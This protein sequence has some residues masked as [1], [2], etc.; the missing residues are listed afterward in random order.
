MEPHAPSYLPR[1][2]DEQLFASLMKGEYVFL[3]DSR[4]KGKS[5]MIAR[6]IVQLKE[7]GVSTVKLDLQRIGANVTAEQWYAGLMVGMGQELGVVDELIAYW[8]SRKSMGPLARWLGAIADVVLARCPGK[9]V[10]FIDE[11]DFVRALDFST[12]EF[13]AG[14][15]DCFNRRSEMSG[16]ERLTFC[17]VG[18]ATPGQLIRNVDITPFNIGTKIELTDFTLDETAR[19]GQI[20]SLDGRNGA[21]LMK[22]VH[23]WVNGHPYL[24]QLLCSRIAENPAIA[25]SNVVD[26]LVKETFFAPE[27]RHTEPNLAAV[28]QRILD[29]DVP[30][31]SIE[32]R[33][34]QVLDLYGRLLRGKGV[35][36]AEENP[37]I[38]SLKLAGVGHQIQG[39]LR[40]R[41]RVYQSVFN[42]GWRQ[43]SLPNAEL[44]RQRGAARLAMLRTAAVA[45]IVV[46]AVS[47]A[48][49][50]ILRI[51][52]DRGKALAML[53]QRTQDLSKVSSDRKV[54]LT[55]LEKRNEELKR[56]SKEREDALSALGKSNESLS[57]T[58]DARKRVVDE[59]ER[60]SSA[61]KQRN[62]E[63]A[64][65]SKERELALVALGTRSKELE[66]K[67]YSGIMSSI[68]LA[69]QQ[70]RFNRV[71]ELVEQSKR[72]P[73]RGWEWGHASMI[74]NSQ[75]TEFQVPESSVFE[76]QPDESIHVVTPDSIYELTANGLRFKRKLAGPQLIPL[77]R[78]GNIRIARNPITRN[79]V[80]RDANSDKIIPAETGIGRGLHFDPES[81]ALLVALPFEGGR[82]GI[83]LRP[84]DGKK[85]TVV[86]ETPPSHA[87]IAN[88]LKDGDIMSLHFGG[89]V[90]RWDPSGRIKWQKQDPY[91]V[92]FSGPPGFSFSRDG[93]LM[94]F[95]DAQYRVLEIRRAS[96]LTFVA[97]TSGPP[98]RA[99]TCTFSPDGSKL[100]VG[101]YDGAVRVYD[102][103]S[104]ALLR[105]FAG[106]AAKIR[107]AFLIGNGD[108]RFASVDDNNRLRVWSF[109]SPMPIQTYQEHKDQV[110]EALLIDRGN[111]LLSLSHYGLSDQTVVARDLR[112]GIVSKR[113]KDFVG[114]F[115]SES[116]VFVFLA[117]GKLEKLTPKNLKVESS[118]QVF[119]D[120]YGVWCCTTDQSLVVLGSGLERGEAASRDYAILDTR[121]M[122]VR[123]RL[124]L[125]WPR[126]G[127][128]PRFTLDRA[129]KTMLAT[130]SFRANR[131]AKLHGLAY[132]ISFPEGRVLK[133][134]ELDFPFDTSH[135]SPN[136][137]QLVIGAVESGGWTRPQILDIG[138]LKVV[139]SLP[140]VRSTLRGF[141]LDP[142][143]KILAGLVSDGPAYLWD[144]ETKKLIATLSPGTGIEGISFS[145][146]GSRVVTSGPNRTNIVWNSRTGEEVFALRY[147]PTRVNDQLGGLPADTPVF[148]SDGR[149]IVMGC[150]DGAVRIFDSL[151]WKDQP[152]AARK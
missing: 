118:I 127:S 22:R 87:A 103:R 110:L 134:F 48:A 140:P 31:L 77:Y 44:R 35:A 113:P 141:G 49:I 37:V 8:D 28:E 152:K 15:R 27:A 1:S 139:G 76:R 39:E 85:P 131:L 84:M 38:A 107:S 143:R 72:S 145:P 41:N 137:R 45:G 10:V 52:R 115:C 46:I 79:V 104:G 96:D 89:V 6:T 54:A 146:D 136:G 13:F 67:N 129:A 11:V 60:Q 83:E 32:E 18:V 30:G 105:T 7:Q 56:I 17:L 122:Q 142:T 58:A 91:F 61:L 64:R 119:N 40:V 94:C 130:M 86:F 19:F 147:E 74:V 135:I 124:T 25:S 4:Q 109:D 100:I 33:K 69:L 114:L 121:S 24:T 148:T 149:K 55:D 126:G 70:D 66:R 5:S 116:N 3:L 128:T 75:E 81:R 12:D 59:L 68:H 51:S 101:S 78:R 73:L 2:A 98:V 36:V 88:F 125:D 151:P 50:G 120:A 63:L 92:G 47:S 111:V 9:I 62:E 57:K 90:V 43:Q 97:K 53:G 14:I 16:F 26:Q 23:Y 95:F 99:S 20:L 71:A 117:D 106:H 29:P 123:S 102:A 34:T 138:T 112:T 93:E 65:V 21:N 133:K 144:L 80:F 150:T 42:E 82:P 108:N 132:L